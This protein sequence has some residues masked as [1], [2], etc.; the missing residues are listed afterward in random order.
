MRISSNGEQAHSGAV[1]RWLVTLLVC[2]GL[3]ACGGD[4]GQT[5]TGTQTK[6]AAA[7]VTQTPGAD[8]KVVSLTKIS[9][10]RVSRTVYDYVFR[11]NVKNTGSAGWT[12]VNVTASA[13]GQGTSIIDGIVQV[14]TLGAG[15]AVTPADTIR[16]RHDRAVPFN[17][18]ALVWNLTGTSAPSATV[19]GTLIVGPPGVP[20]ASVLV[21][22]AADRT[23]ADLAITIDPATQ[24]RYYANQ[25]TAVIK[26]TAT[27][28]QIN[29]ALNAV[30]ARLVF[31][32]LQNRSVTLQV[33][34]PSSLAALMQVAA[35][36]EA[37]GAFDAVAPEFIDTPAA[38]PGNVTR[39]E[40]MAPTGPIFH[41]VATR[42]DTAW[43]ARAFTA[44]ANVEL[45]VVDYFGAGPARGV[46][47][48][49]S[50]AEFA[51]GKPEVHGY[52]V[53]GII[54]GN[55]G[56]PDT[57]EGEITGSLPK[58]MRIHVVD[59]SRNTYILP[60]TSARVS[61][62]E[63]MKHGIAAILR[64]DPGKRFVMNLSLGYCNGNGPDCPEKADAL[65]ERD[66]VDWR[67]FVREIRATANAEPF[68]FEGRLVQV[69]AAGNNL[70]RIAMRASRY[71]AA[72]MRPTGPTTASGPLN[73]A[74]VVENRRAVASTLR[75]APGALS[76]SSNIAGNIGAIGA[77]V[78]SFGLPGTEPV[79]LSG[80]SMASPQ[81]AGIA[82]WMLGFRPTMPAG[83]I[84]R[85]LQLSGIEDDHSPA[86]ALDA[87]AALLKLDRSP[88]DAPVRTALLRATT[89]TPIAVSG[90]FTANDA[91]EFLKAFFP[92][93]Y[94]PGAPPKTEPD[95]S[96]YD[97]NGDG[98]TGVAGKV[99]PFDMSFDATIAAFTPEIPAAYPNGSPVTGLDERRATDFDVLC[100]YVNSD[101]F[102]QSG[103]VRFEQ[104]LEAISN[105]LVPQRRIACNDR[106]VNLYVNATFPDWS[107][108]PAKITM[109]NFV[110]RFPA[111]PA[112]NSATCTNQG[113]P[114]GE[115]G[116]PFF[117]AVVP[118]PIPLFAAIDVIGVPTQAGR[119][120]NRRNCSSFFA[121]A[122]AQ[123]WINATARTVF[124]FGGSVVS[125][126]EYQVRYSNGDPN[127]GNVGKQCTVGNVPGIG[128]FFASF[129]TTACTHEEL[130][131]VTQ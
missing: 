40:A 10:T 108:L 72:A 28:A 129:N 82:A 25:L 53:L 46:E 110:P 99:A 104:E 5:S 83:D 70:G 78:K 47:G 27:V 125:D 102:D 54:A 58:D 34:N 2:T 115:R 55:Y 123:V 20:A 89:T 105:R 14:G 45:I 18:S 66:A 113:E 85:I 73:N 11:I 114:A 29:A 57:R 4:K 63:Y 24:A 31:S 116:T 17:A 51:T 1:R 107:P 111:T 106:V 61:Q 9:E 3:A 103:R 90:Q 98:F 91:I 128:I 35:A 130:A 76:A 100:Y 13:A 44:S 26:K 50:N 15:A 88:T 23:E 59:L 80:T 68:D 38:L 97:L 7:T 16:L 33:P 8:I 117:S 120:S 74:L 71:N 48:A 93:A 96:R 19:P 121:S 77:N 92:E 6:L 94:N 95:L 22:Y 37:S 84:V 42:V 62:L 67:T 32:M 49:I 12:A 41:Q 118:S 112:G 86:R 69:S 127:N 65:L 60:G 124:G 131:R 56:G 119:V 36:L 81:V 87:Y 30:G 122:G 79:F 21:D 64:N 109:S 101:L 75:P 126:W 39:D 43:A 52:H